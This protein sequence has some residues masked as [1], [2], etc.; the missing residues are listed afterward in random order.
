MKNM[1]NYESVFADIN[2]SLAVS[3]V[4]YNESCYKLLA[5]L[6]LPDH[7]MKDLLFEENS[8]KRKLAWTDAEFEQKLTRHLG[9]KCKDYLSFV[10][11]LNR[12]IL[13]LASK[14]KLG[15]KFMVSC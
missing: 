2:C 14:L 11:K 15:P 9:I 12:R 5:P 3:V 4:I 1:K 6:N 13:K 8:E 10:N 7:Q